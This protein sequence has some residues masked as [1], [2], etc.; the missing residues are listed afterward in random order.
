MCSAYTTLDVNSVTRMALA[1]PEPDPTRA[2]QAF[3]TTQA[4]LV[5]IRQLSSPQN[6][7]HL[8]SHPRYDLLHGAS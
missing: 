6:P 8:V 4:R 5:P 1:G 3:D 7:E 2:E